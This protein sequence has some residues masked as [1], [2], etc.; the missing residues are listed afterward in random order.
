MI[1]KEKVMVIESVKMEPIVNIINW[2]IHSVKFSNENRSEHLQGFVPGKI[3]R[4][5]SAI[6][7]FEPGTRRITTFSGR[8][9]ILVGLPGSCE[10]AAYVW[11]FWK[12]MNG[13]VYDRNVTDTYAV[14][15]KKLVM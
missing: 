12:K 1:L 14:Q 9:Y 10:D 2:S 5:T 6:Q 13:V 15:I 3:G 8:V 11:H 7:A 4:V